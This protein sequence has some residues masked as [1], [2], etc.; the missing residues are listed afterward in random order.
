MN[1]TLISI[2]YTKYSCPLHYTKH[3]G[4]L[5]I[6]SLYVVLLPKKG[7][8]SPFNSVKEDVE[9]PAFIELD[10]VCHE[11]I[12]AKYDWLVIRI[13]LRCGQ[14][15]EFPFTDLAW[16]LFQSQG[17]VTWSDIGFVK[18]VPENCRKCEA[19]FPI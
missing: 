11:V 14:S 6:I 5:Y 13:E 1:N 18:S 4:H 8:L 12:S 19:C 7:N 15:W 17:K 9:P 10:R 3:D 16:E 2:N